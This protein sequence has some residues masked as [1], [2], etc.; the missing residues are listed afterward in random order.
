MKLQ[1]TR[2]NET[3]R[4][5][6]YALLSNE[7][8]VANGDEKPK[9]QAIVKNGVIEVFACSPEFTENLRDKIMGG[10]LKTVCQDADAI[11]SNL[12]ITPD[13][14]N[15]MTQRFFERYG[16]RKNYGETLIRIAGSI[17]P[18]SVV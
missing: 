14:E 15:L 8:E 10:L 1:L 9:A 5:L 6:N 3:L 12:S 7:Y 16:F 18:P 2:L 11:N 4:T 17:T 13:R